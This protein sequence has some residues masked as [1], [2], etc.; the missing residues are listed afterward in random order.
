MSSTTDVPGRRT[1]QRE[2]PQARCQ[3]E[4]KASRAPSS[5]SAARC[6]PR[7]AR[8]SAATS[9]SGCARTCTGIDGQIAEAF[10]EL[11]VHGR[12]RFSDEA[13]DVCDRGRQGRPGRSVACGDS[14]RRAAGQQYIVVDERRDRGSRR[15]RERD[16]A[17]RQRGRARRSR[18]DDGRRGRRQRATPRRVP[19]PREASSTAWSRGCRSSAPR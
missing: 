17:R 6:S 10:N 1:R 12:A 14:A 19:A 8:S 16:R 13:G 15:S 18:S 5:S 11:V 2:R 7:C 4:R 3:A 9:R